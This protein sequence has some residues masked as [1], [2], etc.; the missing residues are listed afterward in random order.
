MVCMCLHSSCEEV[1][2]P[3]PPEQA[4][5]PTCV[6]CSQLQ[7]LR[8]LSWFKRLLL[9]FCCLVVFAGFCMRL[10]GFPFVHLTG[11]GGASGH[12]VSVVLLLL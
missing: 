7:R 6:G 1:R 2:L 3:P 12:G 9:L 11:L 8:R 5:R 4:A 10:Q